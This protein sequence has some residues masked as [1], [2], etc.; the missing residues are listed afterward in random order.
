[1]PERT[2]ATAEARMRQGV[3][4]R[5]G[6]RRWLSFGRKLEAEAVIDRPPHNCGTPYLWMGATINRD[7]SEGAKDDLPE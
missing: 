5:Q 2:T 3:N 4:G 7:E 6:W 1:M